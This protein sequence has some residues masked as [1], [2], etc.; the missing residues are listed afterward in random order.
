[1][2][3]GAAGGVPGR[4]QWERPGKAWKDFRAHPAGNTEPVCTGWVGAWH[5]CIFSLE[6]SLVTV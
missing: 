3:L 4:P 5:S 1:M 6:K 2:Q